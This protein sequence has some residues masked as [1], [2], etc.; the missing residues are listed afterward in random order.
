MTDF[1]DRLPR[2]AHMYTMTIAHLNSA[3]NPILYGIFNPAFQRGYRSFFKLII[4]GKTDE[5][6][7]T[8]TAVDKS[9]H[10]STVETIKTKTWITW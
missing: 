7:G 5:Y 6:T 8:R 10:I 1:N 3:L 2:T 9:V 4:Y